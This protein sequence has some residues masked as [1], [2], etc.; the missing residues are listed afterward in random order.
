[1]PIASQPATYGPQA[2]DEALPVLRRGPA[3]RPLSTWACRRSA[4]PIRALEDFNRGEVY[5][6]LHVYVCEQCFLVQL[7]E[8][9]SAEN[10]FSDYAY[11]SSYS[12]SWLKHADNYC[13]KMI[14]AVR[15][16]RT[17]ASRLKWPATT[18]TCC[19]ISSQRHSGA[20]HRAG[21]ERGQSGGRKGRS[22]AGA[23]LRR[24]TGAGT[25]RGR[26]LRRSGA[27]Q[28]RAGAGPGPERFC[29]RPQDS[30]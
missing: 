17:V 19:S 9:E 6:P 5:Y 27:R 8:Y 14:A 4:R 1:M 29:G 12:D 24:A 21:G 15:P 10:I 23:V 16:G 18:A 26:P 20:G 13:S 25:G 30:C 11:F 2:V 28:Q 7:E 22:H 3:T